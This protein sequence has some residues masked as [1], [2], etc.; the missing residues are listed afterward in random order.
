MS[1]PLP[2]TR[3]ARVKSVLGGE[4]NQL[5]DRG[6]GGPGGWWII[7]E[8]EI[9]LGDVVL[10]PAIAGWRRERMPVYPEAPYFEIVPDWICEVFDDCHVGGGRKIWPTYAESG[11]LNGWIL[12]LATQAVENYRLS[13]KYWLYWSAHEDV[14]RAE[15][16]EACEFDLR[17]LF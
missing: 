13:G 3:R 4:I 8:P 9:H 7:D 1:D 2:E 17:A 12:D 10:R 5:F 6:D 15:P 11:I 16:F 14:V